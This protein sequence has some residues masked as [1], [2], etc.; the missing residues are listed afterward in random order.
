VNQKVIQLIR[1]RDE[2]ETPAGS[3]TQQVAQAEV[4]KE[5]ARWQQKKKM[6][7]GHLHCCR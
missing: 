7:L 6:M 1:Q 2:K 5:V 4:E 3:S